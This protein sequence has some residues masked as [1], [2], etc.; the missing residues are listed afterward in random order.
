[1][2]D[3][4]VAVAKVTATRALLSAV[5]AT[6]YREKWANG[7]GSSRAELCARL[8]VAVDSSVGKACNGQRRR[9]AMGGFVRSPFEKFIIQVEARCT[10]T[11]T[12]NI[13]LD[14]GLSNRNTNRGISVRVFRPRLLITGCH[15]LRL[16]YARMLGE[17]HTKLPTKTASFCRA[18]AASTEVLLKLD[19]Y[20]KNHL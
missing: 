6:G 5:A 2:Q 18:R 1:M 10:R 11:Q 7:D 19:I 9:P 4:L 17:S 20:K 14:G 12:N 3:L 13:F 8:F 16:R 15:C